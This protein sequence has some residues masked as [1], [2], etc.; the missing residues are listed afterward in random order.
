[1]NARLSR[2]PLR[3]LAG[4]AATLLVAP[5]VAAVAWPATCAAQQPT[6][7]SPV[8]VVRGGTLVDGTGAPP[9]RDAMV[10]IRDGRIAAVGGRE[11]IPVPAGEK[12]LDAK[13]GW[14]VPGLIDAH[15]HYSQTGW[16]DGRPDAADVRADYPYAEVVASLRDHP[17]RFFDADLCSGVTATFDVGGYPWTRKLQ[18]RGERDPRA[19]HV[20]AAGALLSTVDF[21]LNLPDQRQFVYMASDTAVRNAVRS[22]AA[23]GS[24]AIKVWYIVPASWTRA[25]SARFSRLVHLAGSEADSVGLPLIVHATGLWQA[26]DA[27]RAGARV[28]VHSVFDRPVDD[29]FLRLARD[30][31]VVYVPTLTVVEG[32]PNAFL[33]KGPDELP[34]PTDCVDPG[35]WEKL[36]RGLPD[37]LRPPWARGADARAPENRQLETG[38]ANLKRVQDAGITVALGTDA[39]NPGTLHGPSVYREM[40]LMRQAGLTPMQVLV[41]ATRNA[42]QAMG[43]LHDLGTLEP[44]K[45]GDLVILRSDPLADVGNFRGVVAVVKGGVVVVGPGGSD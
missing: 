45:A 33:G 28:L 1:M 42:A 26:K 8:L 24:A 6:G 41:D 2:R 13:G 27:I 22:A 9:V 10:V 20:A 25:D 14:I 39:G 5:A 29:E 17:D 19:P 3:A 11:A 21:W 36:A 30:H 12:V 18:A 16:F 37:S 32:Y 44:G 23:L 15:V 4:A 43:R 35:T 31:G 38:L 34:Y 7:A 40:D